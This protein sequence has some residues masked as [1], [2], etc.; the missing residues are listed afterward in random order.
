MGSRRLRLPP[1]L[2][3]GEPIAISLPPPARF[4]GI[5]AKS[6]FVSAGFRG[7]TWNRYWLGRSLRIR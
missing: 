6:F 1:V 4:V 7:G 5:V 3:C 2:N